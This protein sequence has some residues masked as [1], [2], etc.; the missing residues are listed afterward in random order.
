MTYRTPAVPRR[1]ML[2]S[3]LITTTNRFRIPD[4]DNIQHDNIPRGM[5]GHACR[6]PERDVRAVRGR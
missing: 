3:G 6:L 5:H 1:I 2:P 4:A